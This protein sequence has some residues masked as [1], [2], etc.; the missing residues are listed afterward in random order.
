MIRY[1]QVTNASFTATY[2]TYHELHDQIEDPYSTTR[3]AYD[4]KP[5]STTFTDWRTQT[6]GCIEER[7]TSNVHDFTDFSLIDVNNTYYDLNLDLVPT[8][9]VATQWKPAHPSVVYL[10]GIWSG[11]GGTPSPA[12]ILNTANEYLQ[13]FSSATM[14]M[15]TACPAAAM[16]LTQ[17]DN[18]V[19]AIDTYLNTLTATGS[20]YHDIGMIWGGRML[21][22]NGIFAAANADVAGKPTNR[23][24]IFLTDGATETM[25]IVY[26]AYGIE[27]LENR[28]IPA[29]M[30]TTPGALDTMVE[31]RFEFACAEVRKRNIT[32][33]VI[34]FGTAMTKP[35]ENCSVDD[36]HRFLANDANELAKAFETIGASLGDLRI[37]K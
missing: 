2:N 3:P 6:Q 21:S 37:T 22:K 35:M 4:Y 36:H 5:I 32:I 19:A 15:L 1:C 17:V 24:L 11:G 12:P 14:S 33:W 20:T 7:Q 9:N 26:S 28:R 16:P 31:R 34:S 10:R 8:A 29:A 18:N 13:P 30:A 23:H 25:D 27:G